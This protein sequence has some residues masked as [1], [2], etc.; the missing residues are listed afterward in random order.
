MSDKIYEKASP[1]KVSENITRDAREAGKKLVSD[2]VKKFE[3]IGFNPK[4]VAPLIRKGVKE[5]AE[6][7]K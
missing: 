3:G 6:D 4:E 5:G 2:M 7:S 1:G